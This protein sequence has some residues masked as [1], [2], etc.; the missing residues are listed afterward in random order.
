MKF[1]VIK[2]CP[3]CKD[4]KARHGK[5]SIL[6]P[7]YPIDIKAILIKVRVAQGCF[8]SILKILFC[9]SEFLTWFRFFKYSFNSKLYFYIN[10]GIIQPKKP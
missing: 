9:I 3:C 4:S 10:P 8:I 2:E 5:S 1:I 7:M 6:K